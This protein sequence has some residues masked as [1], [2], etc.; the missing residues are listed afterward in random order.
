MVA[1][2]TK[3]TTFFYGLL[4]TTLVPLVALSALSLTTFPF[5]NSLLLGLAIFAGGVGHVGSTDSGA[6][7]VL[8]GAV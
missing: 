6:V 3:K 2:Q 4:A 7:L 1:D 8:A 5:D